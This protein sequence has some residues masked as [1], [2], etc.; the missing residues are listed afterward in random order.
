MALAY[1]TGDYA[2]KAIADVFDVHYT[3][4]SRTVRAYE[5]KGVAS[6]CLLRP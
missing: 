3:T 5:S 6:F 2:M 1:L 4:V